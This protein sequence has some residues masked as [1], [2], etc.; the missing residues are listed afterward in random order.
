MEG[1][2][3]ITDSNFGETCLG[4]TLSNKN[5]S[6]RQNVTEPEKLTKVKITSAVSRLNYV[7]LLI[8]PLIRLIN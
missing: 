1:L 4:G 8:N 6:E 5:C 2:C 3:V 7:N